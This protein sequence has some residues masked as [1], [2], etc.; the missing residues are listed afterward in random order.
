M[1]PKEKVIE[2]INFFDKIQIDSNKNIAY[3]FYHLG[4]DDRKKMALKVIDEV[5]EEVGKLNV[6][7]FHAEY[8]E[9]LKE[10]NGE[11]ITNYNS[12]V[13]YWQEVKKEIEKL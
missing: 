5:I 3:T 7:I 6:K 12:F 1:T 2:L 10:I 4:M 13:L 8:G 9:K 11:I